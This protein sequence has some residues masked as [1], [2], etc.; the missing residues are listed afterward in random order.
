M[1][2][3]LEESLPYNSSVEYDWPN[4]RGVLALASEQAWPYLKSAGLPEYIV[5]NP[6]VMLPVYELLRHRHC[7]AYSTYEENPNLVRK[8]LGEE[9]YYAD[10]HKWVGI[11][12]WYDLLKHLSEVSNPNVAIEF[13]RWAYRHWFSGKQIDLIMEEWKKVLRSL[14]ALDIHKVQ[15]EMSDLNFLEPLLPELRKLVS[16]EIDDSIT[17]EFELELID[18][19]LAGNVAEGKNIYLIMGDGLVIDLHDQWSYNKSF[20]Q[21]VTEERSLESYEPLCLYTAIFRPNFECLGNAILREGIFQ[22]LRLLDSHLSSVQ[23][24]KFIRWAED[25][26]SKSF[27]GKV[28]SSSDMS[29]YLSKSFGETS[30]YSDGLKVDSLFCGLCSLLDAKDTDF[31]GFWDKIYPG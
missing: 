27:F 5:N 10:Y 22:A 12:L 21:I 26:S 31:P 17:G 28:T 15:A 30:K 25:E 11:R 6:K 3:V 18:S 1:K 13:D 2:S 7:I 16:R 8:V 20:I 23:K 4:L 29:K 24:K 14:T 9:Y 19:S